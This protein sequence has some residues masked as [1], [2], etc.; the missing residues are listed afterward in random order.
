MPR[1]TG[2]GREGRVPRLLAL[3]GYEAV[4]VPVPEGSVYLSLSSWT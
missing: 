1:E 4:S 2:T 3:G